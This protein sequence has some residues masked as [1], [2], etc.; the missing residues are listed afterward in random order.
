MTTLQRT[1]RN[2]PAPRRRVRLRRRLRQRR[3]LGPRRRHLGADDPAGRRRLAVSTSASGWAAGSRRWTTRSRPSSRPPRRADRPGSGVEAVDD[4]RFEA[5][6]RPARGST[7]PPTSGSR[8]AAPRRP[9]RRRRVRADRRDARDG[10]QRALDQ[11][12]T[13]GLSGR[14]TSRSSGRGS[15]GSTAAYALRGDHR[16]TVFERE[17]EPGGHVK[18][19]DRRRARRSRSRSTPG[20]IVYNERTY[21]RFV[22][23]LAELGVETQPSDMSFGSPCDACGIAYSSRGAA[24]SSP[25]RAPPC[26]R[27]SGG[28][29]PTSAASTA[30]RGRS[31]TAPSRRRRR[32]AT[33]STSAGYGAAVPRPLPRPD[34]VRRLVD[35]GRPDRSSSR[36][37]TCSASSTTT[38]S[39]AIGNAPQWRVVSGG[40]RAYVERMVAALPVAAVRD[41]RSGRRGRAR[42]VG[43]TVGPPRRHVASGSTRSS[44]RPT[45]TT[46]C[47]CS[48]DADARERR[49]SAASSTRTNEVVLHT[50]ER[51]LPANRRARA[52][53][54]SDVGDCRRPGDALTMTYHMNRLQSLPGAGRVLRL[55]QPGR[56]GPARAGH[57][58]ARVQPPDV[59]VPDARGAGASSRR[60]RADRGPGTP[61]R[62]SATGSTRT[63][64]GRLRGG[65]DDRATPTSEAGGMRSHLLEGKVR[66][67]RA[68][69]VHATRSSTTSTTSRSTSPSSTTSIDGCGS[70][71]RN[72]RASSTFRD[73]DHLPAPA[74]DL[75]A[76]VRAHLRA[77]GEDPTGWRDHARHEPAGPRLRVQPG[78]LLPLPRRRRRPARRGRRGPQHVRRAAPLHAPA[79]AG[80]DGGRSRRRWTRS[81]SCRRSST[82]TAGTRS[83][84]ATTPTALRS[85][86]T[87]RQDEAPL[88]STSLVL[89]RV[90]LTD[91]IAAADARSA[92]RSMTHRTIALIHWHALRL[93][94]RGVPFL[95]HGAA[96]RAGESHR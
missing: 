59:H 58:R 21:P 35:R 40:S 39:S 22:G 37:T 10:M 3:A 41:R 62:T 80:D 85:R 46:R 86:S 12:A 79:P 43:V 69:P 60:S 67:R 8:A 9:V 18:T 68:R 44:W 24:G 5:D 56:R 38:A 13:G 96:V 30:T 4:I 78:E 11:L 55:A 65:G 36:S 31:S 28:C 7:T 14:W 54:T 88:L 94:L 74:T 29:S 2:P 89:R 70:F 23:L 48:R 95:R 1:D 34:H 87:Q 75:D 19:V 81:S 33:G 53:G 57:R 32:S 83:T 71:S 84:S 61:A 82:W 15:A 49:S 6:R 66:H 73:R 91:R 47:A 20:F 90:P 50:D 76:D 51:V 45:P 27:R 25:T 26:A 16:V 72:R 92:T 17:A 63:A 52:R 64:A 42:P 93:W 77:E